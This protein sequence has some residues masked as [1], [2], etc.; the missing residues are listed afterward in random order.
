VSFR[1]GAGG[2]GRAEPIERRRRPQES[3]LLFAELVSSPGS[4]SAVRSR[5]VDSDAKF[6]VSACA[7]ESHAGDLNVPTADSNLSRRNRS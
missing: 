2:H 1:R 7:A 3:Q 6:N 5:H 4:R